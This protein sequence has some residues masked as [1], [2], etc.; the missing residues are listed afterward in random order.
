METPGPNDL[1]LC[2]ECPLRAEE[3]RVLSVLRTLKFPFDQYGV[4]DEEKTG[5]VSLVEV[6]LLQK[7]EMSQE[8]QQS[9]DQLSKGRFSEDMEVDPS[10]AQA[11]RKKI[12]IDK[13]ECGITRQEVPTVLWD[14]FVSEGCQGQTEG[15]KKYKLFG[16]RLPL[17]GV[18]DFINRNNVDSLMKKT[19]VSPAPTPHE[20]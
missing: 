9:L 1:T 18:V 4:P 10:L 14:E 11:P 5:G 3:E 8:L 7:R 16:Q 13:V 20:E 17:C 2:E 15:R 19:V 6:D 12:F